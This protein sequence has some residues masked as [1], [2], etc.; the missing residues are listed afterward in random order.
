MPIEILRTN[1]DYNNHVAE[2]IRTGLCTKGI[3]G[4]CW[5]AKWCELPN[6]IFL[7][8]LHLIYIG[9]FD[10]LLTLWCTEYRDCFGN[11]NKFYLSPSKRASLDLIL[12]KVRYPNEISRVQRSINDL[13]NLKANEKRNL[14][15]YLAIPML[16]RVLGA[17]Y[18]L[19]FTVYV[20]AIR[21]MCQ[22]HISKEDLKDAKVLIN[23]FI[24]TFPTYYGSHNQDY[25]LHAH[26][27]LPD[28]VESIGGLN[29]L[30][31]FFFEGDYI[32][33]FFNTK[34]YIFSQNLNLSYI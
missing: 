33:L 29:Y 17:D 26:S 32:K 22:Y 24:K 7:C 12:D 16:E 8:A 9:T 10:K 14:L 31:G 27:H 13:S 15:F 6:S 21:L 25:K 18:Y 2:S 19:H 1:S 11:L 5:I 28:Q 23:H 30:N 3:F 4:P 20:T 34:Y